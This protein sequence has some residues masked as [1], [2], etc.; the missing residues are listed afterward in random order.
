MQKRVTEIYEAIKL[1]KMKKKIEMLWIWGCL[2]FILMPL[3]MGQEAL[4]GPKTIEPAEEFKL[5]VEPAWIA[6]GQPHIAWK[7]KQEKKIFPAD[8]NSIVEFFFN[9]LP[10]C[11][12][13]FRIDTVSTNNYVMEVAWVKDFKNEN[14]IERIDVPISTGLASQLWETYHF[15]MKFYVSRGIP[16]PSSEGCSVTFRCL[17]GDFSVW[18][19]FAKNPLSHLKDLTR[20]CNEIVKDV[21]KNG[22]ILNEEKYT[23]E[24]NNYHTE[25]FFNRREPGVPGK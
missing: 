14:I 8:R 2:Q 21:Q 17:A 16:L 22:G 24:I 10:H 6:Y 23:I 5:I 3:M 4:L 7:S 12:Q 15:I 9:D 25:V 19:F 1:I 11:A 13:G 20:I 18:T